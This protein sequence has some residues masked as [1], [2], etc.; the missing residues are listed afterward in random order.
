M[1]TP[2]G[3]SIP[4]VSHETLQQDLPLEEQR[5]SLFEISELTGISEEYLVRLATI[6]QTEVARQEEARRHLTERQIQVLDFISDE[7]NRVD[8][9]PTIRAIASALGYSSHATIHQ[10]LVVL[11]RKGYIAR[12]SPYA[13]EIILLRNSFD[14][15]TR[16]TLGQG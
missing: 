14:F 2:E 15:N 16:E 1:S 9:T 6:G 4:G 5:F 8:K 3:E 13:R 7:F 11:E 10:F 12:V